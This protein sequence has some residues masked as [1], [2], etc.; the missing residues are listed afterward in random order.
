MSHVLIGQLR[1]RV[2]I[3]YLTGSYLDF[4]YP[5]EFKPAKSRIILNRLKRALFKIS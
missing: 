1:A 2:R 5:A 4:K 3:L